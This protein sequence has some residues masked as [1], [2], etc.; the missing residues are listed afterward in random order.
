[1]K[2]TSAIVSLLVGPLMG[3]GLIVHGTSQTVFV[4][5]DPPSAE[6]RTGPKELQYWTPATID[7]AR[8]HE[9]QLTFELAGYAPATVAL[10]HRVMPEIVVLDLVG[11]AGIGLLADAL[12]GAWYR[13]EPA[14]PTVTLVA[15]SPVAA[16]LPERV[17][18]TVRPDMK[19]GVTVESSR[20]GVGIRVSQAR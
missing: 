14:H 4:N 17:S 8:K 3:C 6:V 10:R 2:T 20:P 12:T 19:G 16:G 7:L 1:M 18:V 9:Y 13:L 15:T 11:T 5:S